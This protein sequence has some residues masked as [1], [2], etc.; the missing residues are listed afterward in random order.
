GLVPSRCPS[1]PYAIAIIIHR[2]AARAA[3]RYATAILLNLATS[4]L[5]GTDAFG[6]GSNRI[7]QLVCRLDRGKGKPRQPREFLDRSSCWCGLPI[8]IKATVIAA[9]PLQFLFD[10]P[11][12][13]AA[14][15]SKIGCG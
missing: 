12:E 7:E 11:N 6:P 13:C 4:A 5:K 15:Q 9:D 2:K 14:F 1:S 8:L 3:L 10:R